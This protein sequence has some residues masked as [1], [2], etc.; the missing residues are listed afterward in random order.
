MCIDPK[1][2]M[3]L[4]SDRFLRLLGKYRPVHSGLVTLNNE[5]LVIY[6]GTDIYDKLSA[7]EAKY[8]GMMKTMIEQIFQ[9]SNSPSSSPLNTELNISMRCK[10]LS[11]TY[12]HMFQV[13]KQDAKVWR[14]TLL[15]ITNHLEQPWTDI[16]IEAII[17]KIFG[18]NMKQEEVFMTLFMLN[19]KCLE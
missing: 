1:S 8:K 16:I 9:D 15:A 13:S 3:T 18:L 2:H 5:E 10:L 19:K 17:E 11:D 12:F 14:K 6:L 7:Y 4:R